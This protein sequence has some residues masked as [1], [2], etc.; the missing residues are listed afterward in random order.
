MAICRKTKK[1]FDDPGW[2]SRFI[3]VAVVVLEDLDNKT[4]IVTTYTSERNDEFVCDLLTFI[5]KK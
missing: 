1:W 4:S 5:K 2:F 3:I